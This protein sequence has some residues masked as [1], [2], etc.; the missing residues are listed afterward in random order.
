M[1]TRELIFKPGFTVWRHSNPGTRVPGFDIWWVTTRKSCTIKATRRSDGSVARYTH[2][3]RRSVLQKRW[4][5]TTW[6]LQ[7]RAYDIE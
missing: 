6:A 7:V 1:Q 2:D 3:S 5:N 4:S